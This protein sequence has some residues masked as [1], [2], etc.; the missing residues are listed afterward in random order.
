MVNPQSVAFLEKYQFLGIPLAK[1]RRVLV[2]LPKSEYSCKLMY[3]N[4]KITFGKT[5]EPA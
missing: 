1:K 3:N 4:T 2:L 5:L